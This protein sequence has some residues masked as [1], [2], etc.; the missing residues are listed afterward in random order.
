[1]PLGERSS[2]P[3][4]AHVYRD[5]LNTAHARI[6]ELER[7]LARLRRENGA[8]HAR[9]AAPG[10]PVRVEGEALPPDVQ[11]RLVQRRIR[12][13]RRELRAAF[14]VRRYAGSAVIAVTAAAAFVVMAAASIS[15]WPL[16]VA[17]LSMGAVARALV[18]TW[19]GFDELEDRRR[20]L[21]ALKYELDTLR[22][23]RRHDASTLA[24]DAGFADGAPELLASAARSD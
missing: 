22:M 1:M 10:T 7:E 3:P 8:L 23:G 20:Q 17:I 16:A 4:A 9:L 15:S 2:A 24:H 6:E 13:L 14:G 11:E 18:A 12:T 21:D 5:P 19:P